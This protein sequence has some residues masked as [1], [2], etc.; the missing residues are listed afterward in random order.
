MLN[1]MNNVFINKNSFIKKFNFEKN[2]IVIEANTIAKEAES[3]F[4]IR[5]N[6]TVVLVT[7]CISSEP[8]SGSFVP[9][10]VDFQDNLYSAGK[11]PG[12][13]FKREGKP[14]EFCVLSS[15]IID[16]SIRNLF[17]KNFRN[18][19]QII[20]SPLSIDY[21][22]DVRTISIIATSLALNSSNLPINILFSSVVVGLVDGEIIVNPT[23]E[24][25]EVS[26]LELFLTGTN[27]E[28]TMIEMGGDQISEEKLLEAIK[29]G[30]DYIKK[31]IGLQKESLEGFNIVKKEYKYEIFDE[32][33]LKTEILEKFNVEIKDLIENTTNILRV[34]KT[35][36]LEKIIKEFFLKI[37]K[38]KEIEN[39]SEKLIVCFWDILKKKVRDYTVENKMRIDGRDFDSIREISAQ[40]DF[41]SIVHGSSLFNRGQTQTLSILTLGP[42]SDKQII[43]NITTQDFKTFFH[44]YKALPYSIGQVKWLRGASRREVGHGFL[45]EKAL[46]WIMPTIDEFPY[47]IRIVSEVLGSNGSSSQAAICSASLS[48]MAAG[49]PIKAQLAGIATGL[50]K[51]GDKYHLLSDIQAWEDFFGDMDFK[52]S[53]SKKGICSIQ[54]DLKISGLPISIIE[55]ILEKAKIDRLKILGT[56]NKV[57]DKPRKSLSEHAIKYKKLKIEVDEIGKLVGPNGKN[58]KKIIADTDNTSIDIND[59]G[60]VF[61]YHKNIEMINKAVKFILQKPEKVNVGDVFF[62]TVSKVVDFGVFVKLD[63]NYK[64]EGLIH[65]SKL[66]NEYIK[67]VSN[68]IKLEQKV[69]VKII[70]I[71]EKNQISF[72]L[73][74]KL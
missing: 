65:V 53:G 62:G 71:N 11:I 46:K 22:I 9:L 44:H 29:I 10:S 8:I 47:T 59:D 24:Q 12:S 55:K 69:K 42:L 33:L 21:T 20:V 16:R 64:T 56:L 30:H 6:K 54:V 48:L 40:I 28:I 3:T 19:V 67:D 74:E 37:E 31:I 32:N 58:I 39:F 68:F 1:N 63:S 51:A 73:L 26:K 36:K 14:S 7:L 41:L 70:N 34:K 66:S 23:N 60:T 72:K 61:I 15:R 18:Q 25:I 50:I 57:I 38:Y 52:V 43:D 27:D 13:F 35:K 49:V 4:L 17:P 5:W 45:G 2:K